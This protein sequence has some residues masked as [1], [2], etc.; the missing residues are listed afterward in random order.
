[1]G[2][3]LVTGG[4]GF[5]GSH[6]IDRLVREGEK[7]RVL[8]RPTSSLKYISDHIKNNSVEIVTGDL[9]DPESLKIACQQISAIFHTAAVIDL[10]KSKETFEAINIDALDN[11]VEIACNHRVRRFIYVSTIGSYKWQQSPIDENVEQQPSNIYELSKLEG[12]NIVMRAHRNR[13]LEA[14]IIEPSA[15]YGPRAR[16][17]VPEMLWYIQRSWMPMIDGGQKRLNMVYVTDVVDS[18]L[19]AYRKQEATGER[20][21]IGSDES[22]TYKEILDTLAE[23]LGLQPLR[24]SIPYDIAKFIST[25]I[26]YFSK[27]F[28]IDTLPLWNYIDYMATDLV[29]NI[30]KAESILGYKPRVKLYEGLINTVNWFAMNTNLICPE[31]SGLMVTYEHRTL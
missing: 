17:V 7:V 24:W 14:V 12:E 8:I 29:I 18:L 13:G 4:T 26:G 22:Y 21:I 15:I 3:I 6:L 11:L 19:L 25:L 16:I 31:K 23:I 9:T 1:M 10:S 28:N 30:E 5:L 27:L 20:F 2:K